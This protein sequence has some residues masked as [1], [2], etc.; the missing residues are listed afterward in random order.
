[1]MVLNIIPNRIL[2][3]AVMDIPGE[4]IDSIRSVGR[5]AVLTGAGI[6]AES[7]IPTFR[8]KNGIW[9]KVDI[10]EVATPE[11]FR[12][13]PVKV[14]EFHEE[15]QRNIMSN[16]PNNAHH[17]L[18]EM[19]KAFAHFTVITQN[20]DQYHQDAGSTEVIELH[21]NAWRVKCIEEGKVTEDLEVPKKELPPHCSCGSMLRPDVVWFNEPLPKAALERA[22]G[23]VETC[24]L[25]LV[26]GTSIIVQP[27]ASL[28]FIAFENGLPILEFNLEPTPI[29]GMALYSFFGKAAETLPV[30]WDSW[31]KHK[32]L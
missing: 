32:K 29:S 15:F 9:D 1:M 30:F 6:S 21:G 2:R 13:S 12:R 5:V 19:E 22:F 23:E 16:K 18:A 11:G 27:A 14:W 7:G 26:V 25:M 4:V 28:P 8:G 10:D 20:I 24:E 31:K 17:A 3:W